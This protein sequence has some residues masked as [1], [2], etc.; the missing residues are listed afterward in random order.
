[1]SNE[2]VFDGGYGDG[3]DGRDGG[4]EDGGNHQYEE[5]LE[6]DGRGFAGGY[7]FGGDG[8]ASSAHQEEADVQMQE[9]G[10]A[11]YDEE[12]G[13]LGA[14][15]PL[16]GEEGVAQGGGS[17]SAAVAA[18]ELDRLR[19]ENVRLSRELECT[20][21]RL[22]VMMGEDLR[23][24]SP[25]PDGEA[26]ADAAEVEEVVRFLFHLCSIPCGGGLRFN[27][28]A[29]FAYFCFS[30]QADRGSPAPPPSPP[31]SASTSSNVPLGVGGVQIVV[32]GGAREQQQA[33]M[34]AE[35]FQSILD[36]GARRWGSV[37]NYMRQM[38]RHLAKYPK[39]AQ[40]LTLANQRRLDAETRLSSALISLNEAK[41]A[42]G[43]LVA[44]AVSAER[45][46]QALQQKVMGDGPE[47]T[48]ASLRQQ[49]EQL[50]WSR[51]EAVQK[52][53]VLKADVAKYTMGLEVVEK[54]R[55]EMEEGFRCV[56]WVGCTVW[57]LFGPG[58]VTLLC[59]FRVRVRSSL[60]AAEAEAAKGVE[61]MKQLQLKV[62]E[63]QAQVEGLQVS[64][65]ARVDEL[66]AA[67][68]AAIRESDAVKESLV[69]MRAEHGASLVTL[70][71]ERDA[72][73][74]GLASFEADSAAVVRQKE[75]THAM[76][77]ARMRT[78]SGLKER[79]SGMRIAELEQRLL[80][81]SG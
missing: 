3:G 15:E 63:L 67:L 68:A 41:V 61:E 73:V 4:Y 12:Y 23:P 7:S 8:G 54:L 18:E 2:E 69:A 25:G 60:A 48:V 27:P 49:I 1:M 57:V 31:I 36:D 5:G 42:K 72:A 24:I 80:Q 30:A 53:A 62:E 76:V 55:V 81:G 32:N 75:Q 77:V 58:D 51:D 74:V 13:L 64:S 59:V 20:R 19:E 9:V 38:D 37:N 14:D 79:A 70:Q 45:A 21:A 35:G 66:S 50:E 43:K 22:T 40:E 46:L 17:P 71:C 33:S 11:G 56:G 65:G 6:D 29:P 10:D 52:H 44:R 28:C 26:P 16:E 34:I 47:A 39:F 78:E